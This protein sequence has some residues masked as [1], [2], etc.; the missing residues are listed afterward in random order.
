MAA[1]SDGPRTGA[2]LAA[3]LETDP[4]TVARR[5]RPLESMGLVSRG[6]GSPKDRVYTLIREPVFRDDVWEQL[7]V[8]TRRAAAAAILAQVHATAVTAVDSGGFDRAELHLSRNRLELDGDGWRRAA[9]VLLETEARLQQLSE[10]KPTGPVVPA[11]AVMMLF[12]TTV[13]DHREPHADDPPAFS[14]D[15]AREAVTD[16]A[17][18]L[19]EMV[20]GKTTPWEAIVAVANELRVVARAGLV[21]RDRAEAPALTDS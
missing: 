7:P 8:T 20:S 17:E 19:D 3:A 12:E 11:D 6:P 13:T 2:A 4:Q 15:E 21:E 1:L 14:E 18:R 10:E 9:D 5:A 16:L